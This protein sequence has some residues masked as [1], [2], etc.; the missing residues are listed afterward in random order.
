MG[1]ARNVGT[2]Q[3]NLRK[4]LAVKKLKFEQ[5]D[6]TLKDALLRYRLPTQSYY[7]IKRKL[8]GPKKAA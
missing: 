5:P 6:V 1:G 4:Y 2:T 8:D 7:R 3:E